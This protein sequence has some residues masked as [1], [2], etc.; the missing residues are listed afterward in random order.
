MLLAC[1]WCFYFY[2]S[3]F[4][5]FQVGTEGFNVDAI[6]INN[7]DDGILGAGVCDD[8]PLLFTRKNAIISIVP[9]SSDV[10]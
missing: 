4:F 1:K 9:Y 5:F 3:V 6:D 10:R 2:F 8:V 7:S